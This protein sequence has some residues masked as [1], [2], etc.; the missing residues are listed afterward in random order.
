MCLLRAERKG[1]AT[2]RDGYVLFA[3]ALAEADG[4][5]HCPLTAETKADRRAGTACHE[6]PALLINTARGG[7]VD[8]GWP[9]S[10]PKAGLL[11]LA[12]RRS[13][14]PQDDYP[15]LAPFELLAA[16]EFPAQRRQ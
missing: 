6:T 5:L 11:A 16:R 15:P 10:S 9:V 13:E 2:C 4:M 14:P 8:E 3:T 7:L 1:A 12:C